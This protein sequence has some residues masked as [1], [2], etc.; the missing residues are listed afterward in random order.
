[1][2]PTKFPAL[3][4]FNKEHKPGFLLAIIHY[5]YF[6]HRQRIVKSGA[7]IEFVKDKNTKEIAENGLCIFTDANKEMENL[8]T[9]PDTL[10]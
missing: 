9:S 7:S 4:A 3:C 10:R 8:I 1:V 6:I 2:H 5:L